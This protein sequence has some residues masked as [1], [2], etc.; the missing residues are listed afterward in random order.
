MAAKVI[1]PCIGCVYFAVCG[2]NA[3]THPCA[4]RK[5]KSEK[6]AEDKHE[7]QKHGAVLR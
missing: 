3:R 6:K 1:H 7:R 4:G 2:E 5:T